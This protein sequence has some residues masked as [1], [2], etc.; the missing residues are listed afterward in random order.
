MTK[1][2]L[3]KICALGMCAAMMLNFCTANAH[4]VTYTLP[5]EYTI[6]SHAAYLYNL[7]TQTEVMSLNAQEQM[8]PASTA[9]IMTCL[10]ALEHTADLDTEM[11]SYPQSVFN[12]MSSFMSATGLSPSDISQA[13]VQPG[14]ELTMRKAL[15]CLMLQSD[16]YSAMAIAHH[17]CD[18]DSAAFVQMMNARAQELGAVNTYFTNPHG[19]YEPEMVTT[20]YDMFLISRQAMQLDSF[21]DICST[22]TIDISP[23]NVS[24]HDDNY[25]LISTIKTMIKGSDYYYEPIAGIKTGTLPEVGMNYVSSASRDG[26]NYLLVLMGAPAYDEEG[27][28]LP[29]K[30]PF[31]DAKTIYEW[32]FDTFETTTLYEKG[33]TVGQ[34]SVN[35]SAEDDYVNLL[36]ADSFHAFVPIEATQS[37][38]GSSAITM[39]LNVPESIDAPISFGQKIGTMDVILYGEVVGSVDVIAKNDVNRSQ[40]KYILSRISEIFSQF[41]IKFLLIFVILIVAFYSVLMILRNRYRKRRRRARS[42]RR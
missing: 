35:L 14:E 42:R 25:L 29:E 5:D 19:L 11:V 33:A 16:C 3:S 34:V 20:A 12:E 40:S 38:D 17:I 24:R 2:F 36:A 9:K 41:W 15:Y 30:A 37:G 4:A 10:L 18:G 31:T 23:T 21:M 1:R 28:A 7:D 22:P 8:P 6:S 32:A 27:E 39:R 26:Y 13:D